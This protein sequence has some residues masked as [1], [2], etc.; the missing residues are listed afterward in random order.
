MITNNMEQN[1]KKKKF[2]ANELN[3]IWIKLN[4]CDLGR[5]KWARKRKQQANIRYLGYFDLF[6]FIS[7]LEQNYLIQT[8]KL[9][10]FFPLFRQCCI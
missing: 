4:P 3:A 10:D 1:E 7:I 2:E 6:I 5:E 9:F 8:H